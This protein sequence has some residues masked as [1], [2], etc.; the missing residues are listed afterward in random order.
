MFLKDSIDVAHGA[1][2]QDADPGA[3]GAKHLWI[4]ATAPRAVKKRNDDDDDWDLLGYLYVPTVR[5]VDD[6]DNMLSTDVI[7]FLDPT[8]AAFTFTLL[9]IASW[10]VPCTFINIADPD[11]SSNV[12]TLDADGAH[13]IGASALTIDLAPGD[14]VTLFPISATRLEIIG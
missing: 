3:V 11:A 4:L 12:V 10:L 8:S 1:Y 9:T 5:T 7:V 14:K 2:I 13:T 6:T